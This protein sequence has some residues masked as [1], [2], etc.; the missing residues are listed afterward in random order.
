MQKKSR[1]RIGDILLAA[2]AISEEQLKKGLQLQKQKGIQLGKALIQSGFITQEKIMEAISEQLELPSIYLNTYQI[3]TQNLALIEENFART[4]NILPLFKI[5]NTLTI[6]MVDPLDVFTID[7]LNQKLN[8]EIEAAV[9]TEEDISSAFDLYYGTSGKMDEVVQFMQDDDE[10]DTSTDEQEILTGDT[11][12]D[13][14]P[15]IRLVNLIFSQAVKERA[16]DIHIEPEED[17]LRVRFRVDGVLREM[18]VQPKNLQYAIIS[19]IK[20][21]SELNIAERRMPQDGRFQIKIDKH[22][23]DIRVST[24]PTANGEN[25]VM[26]IL[27][28]TNLIVDLND[29]GFTQKALKE[30]KASL[31]RPYGIILVTGPT[32]SGKTTTLYSALHAMNSLSKNIITIE[33]PV[34]YRLKIIRQSQVNT[35]IGMT[36]A[37]GLRSIL[38]QDPDVIMV[39]E[40]RDSETAQVAVQAALTGHLVLST[41][42]TNDAPGAVTR[43]VDMDIEPFLVSSSIICVIAQRLVRKIC[44]KCKESYNGS[45]ALVKELML[46]PNKEYKF[47]RGKGCRLCKDSGYKGRLALFEVLLIDDHIRKMI[48]EKASSIDIRE[49]SL[50]QGMKT[51]RQDGLIKALKGLTSVEEVINSTQAIN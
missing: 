8:L 28:K 16:S 36:F 25:I 33:D 26:R 14:A 13:E 47:F 17:L 4:K 32:G 3:D 7:E 50:S 15:I 27:D 23:I 6:A 1:Q 21:M 2:K 24:I 34:E 35:K 40:I 31:V 46:Q 42:H 9:C 38:R 39:G 44:P 48:L 18:F 43:L 41:L 5:D 10:G 30:F 22:D 29:L 37:A 45:D 49:Y 19:R 20:I 51:L 11:T 12:A